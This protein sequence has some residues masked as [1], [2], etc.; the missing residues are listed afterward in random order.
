M[1]GDIESDD[2]PAIVGQDDHHVEEPKRRCDDDE[3]ID[4]GN[5][6]ALIS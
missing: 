1:L 3:H 6:R 2:A 4:C 5:S